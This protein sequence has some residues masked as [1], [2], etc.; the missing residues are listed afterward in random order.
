MTIIE[1]TRNYGGIDLKDEPEYDEPVVDESLPLFPIKLYLFE[2]DGR[3]GAPIFIENLEE[4]NHPGT[5]MLVKAHI[6][7]GLEVRMTDPMDFCVFHA[8]NGLILFPN[9]VRDGI[10]RQERS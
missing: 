10:D 6:Q 1:T 3:Y 7:R 8:A 2:P 5:Q 9:E 4:L